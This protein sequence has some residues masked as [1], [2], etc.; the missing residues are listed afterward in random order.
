MNTTLQI[1]TKYH[2]GREVTRYVDDVAI[3]EGH[4][5]GFS[6]DQDKSKALQFHHGDLRLEKVEL[7]IQSED[8][9]GTDRISVE[10]I[11]INS[12]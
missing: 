12:F 10:I 4:F 8:L 1:R 11:R 7:A 6:A 9:T 5:S 3:D 2:D